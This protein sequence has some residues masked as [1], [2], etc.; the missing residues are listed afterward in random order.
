M[1][2]SP[3]FTVRDSAD[4]ALAAMP[5]TRSSYTLLSFVADTASDPEIRQ[6]CRRLSLLHLSDAVH[7]INPYPVWPWPGWN[8]RTWEYTDPEK[9]DAF[10]DR[11]NYMCSEDGVTMTQ[12]GFKGEVMRYIRHTGRWDVAASTVSNGVGVTRVN[13]QDEDGRYEY[14]D[15]EK[16][17]LYELMHTHPSLINWKKVVK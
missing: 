8:V 5:G 12:L 4:R 1:L 10:P 15:P 3:E 7:E 11:R 16:P 6:R 13:T 2:G 17:T 9:G 14:E